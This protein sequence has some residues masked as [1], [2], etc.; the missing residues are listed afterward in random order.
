MTGSEKTDPERNALQ[1]TERNADH[2]SETDKNQRRDENV[3]RVH[4][5]PD[6]FPGDV[7]ALHRL[8]GG[9][10]GRSDDR[11]KNQQEQPAYE[12]G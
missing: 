9:E 5:V 1:I 11:R 8:H 10:P 7:P 4:A 6:P 2:E 12:R 3:L